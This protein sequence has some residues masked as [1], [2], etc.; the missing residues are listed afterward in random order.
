ML[1]K[2]NIAIWILNL[3]NDFYNKP[4]KPLKLGF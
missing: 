4:M 2:T 1:H 3:D